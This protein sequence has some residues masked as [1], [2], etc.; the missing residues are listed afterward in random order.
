[1]QEDFLV[2]HEVPLSFALLSYFTLVRSRKILSS[3]HWKGRLQNFVL[4][5][6]TVTLRAERSISSHVERSRQWKMSGKNSWK[7]RCY[8]CL[9]AIMIAFLWNNGNIFMPTELCSSSCIL[10]I[11]LA[12]QQTCSTLRYG[13][14]SHANLYL[15]CALYIS[16]KKIYI[17]SEAK[18]WHLNRF[19]H[20]SNV[21]F[22]DSCSVQCDWLCICKNNCF[23]NGLLF[24]II[25]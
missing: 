15:A 22:C 2:W 25:I 10:L 9:D 16:L 5:V 17:V 11:W 21:I 19:T 3:S 23:L 12:I 7:M 1:M 13:K 6:V 14:S 24:Q 4:Y 20:F 8:K 18:H